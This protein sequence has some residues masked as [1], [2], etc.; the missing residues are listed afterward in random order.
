MADAAGEARTQLLAGTA[1]TEERR[2]IGGVQTSLLVAGEGPPLVLL[3]GGIEVGGAYWTPVVDRLA[4][5]H[6]VI[7]PDVPGLGESAPLPRLDAAAFDDWLAAVI[8]DAC[9]AQPPVVAHSL[10]GSL[11]AR[12]AVR[13][14]DLLSRLVIYGAPGIGPYRMPIGLRTAAVRFA[15]RPSPRAAE[16]LERRAFDDLDGAV[17]RDPEWMASF[18]SYLR[19]RG[20][21]GHVKRA[22]RQLAGAGTKRIDDE[23]LAGIGIPIGLVWGRRDRFVPVALAER[24]AELHGWPLRQVDDAGHVP[25]IERPD[26]FLAALDAVGGR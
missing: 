2:A 1:A 8:A 16:R 18:G 10:I 9:D 5:R 7:A 15:I 23:A 3:H 22:M 26:Q 12:F 21:V 24:A 20:A 19:E 14:G 11:A 13:R 6:R 4:E 25:H 17:S